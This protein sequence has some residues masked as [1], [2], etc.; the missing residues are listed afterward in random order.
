MCDHKHYNVFIWICGKCNTYIPLGV[1]SY[2]LWLK[3]YCKGAETEIHKL[4]V[5]NTCWS[6]YLYCCQKYQ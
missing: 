5:H 4:Y 1:N 6:S 2:D 3:L